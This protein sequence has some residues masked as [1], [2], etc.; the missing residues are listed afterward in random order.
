MKKQKGGFRKII[1]VSMACCM[2]T[3]LAVPV[4]FAEETKKEPTYMRMD[5]PLKEENNW[6]ISNELIM[7]GEAFYTVPKFEVTY[8]HG[9]YGQTVTNLYLKHVSLILGEEPRL[10]D[11]KL[12]RNKVD[13][14][15]L[16]AD[17]TNTYNVWTTQTEL[18]KKSLESAE[19]GEDTQKQL[20]AFQE[21]ESTEHAG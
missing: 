7:P 13:L 16:T 21:G 14:A 12:I 1:G 9:Y 5:H 3:N 15:G 4:S 17:R 8:D 20:K 2:L 6:D 18:W 10:Y 19:M 11:S